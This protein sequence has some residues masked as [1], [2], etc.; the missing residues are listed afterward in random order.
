[1]VTIL[2]CLFIYLFLVNC[3]KKLYKI[4]EIILSIMEIY[5]HISVYEEVL[6]PLANYLDWHVL[7]ALVLKIISKGWKLIYVP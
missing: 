5:E 6:V 4:K 3:D 1:M 2:M 7:L